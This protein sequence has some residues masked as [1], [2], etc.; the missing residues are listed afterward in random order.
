MVLLGVFSFVFYLKCLQKSYKTKFIK[1]MKSNY[2][3]LVI[4]YRMWNGKQKGSI[5]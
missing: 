4:W 5:R 1:N 3:T 2:I